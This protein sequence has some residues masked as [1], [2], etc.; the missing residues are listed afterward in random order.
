MNFRVA[1]LIVDSLIAHGV[2]RASRIPAKV[3]L[4]SLTRYTNAMRSIS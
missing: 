1:D 3:F 4:R 2:D